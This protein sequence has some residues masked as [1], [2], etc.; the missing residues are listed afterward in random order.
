MDPNILT[1]E[2]LL[3]AGYTRASIDD[4][5]ERE[6][7]Q[8]LRR[9]WYAQL[10]ALPDAVAAMRAG[11]HL[12]C[13]SGCRAHGLWVPAFHQVHAVYPRGAKPKRI[14]GVVFHHYRATPPPA[15][16][17]PLEDCLAQVVRNHDVESAL[18]VVESA[19][20][21]GFITQDEAEAMVRSSRHGDL[22]RYLSQAKSGSE[23]RARLFFQQRRVP[24]RSLVQIPGVGE[25]DL[26]VGDRLIVECDSEAH[27]TSMANR[28][29]D[30]NRDLNAH[31]DR[32]QRIRLSYGQI[33]ESWAGTQVGLAAVIKQRRHTHRPRPSA[34]RTERGRARARARER[35]VIDIGLDGAPLEN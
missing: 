11:C 26:L 35:T 33:W 5:L 20:N 29:V 30:G 17:W 9:G 2:Q 34:A 10:G 15:A 23:T 22:R 4:A 32:Y 1:Y 24:V 7:L 19:V 6:V 13:L 21:K 14:P 25:V 16:V 28:F 31:L 8:R 18:V 12:G 3:E 27:H